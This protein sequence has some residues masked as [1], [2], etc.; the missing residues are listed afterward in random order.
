MKFS[1]G[2]PRIH[3]AFA[4]SQCKHLNHAACRSLR[5]F[6]E[7]PDPVSACRASGLGFVAQP[8]NPDG[9][10]AN[11]RK[12][13]G[14]GAASAPIPLMTWPPRRPGSVSVL[15]LNQQIIV[16]GFV[17]QP[18]N[19]TVFWWTA[20]NPACKFRPHHAKHQARQAFHR[21]HADGL[22]SL[23]LFNDLAATLHRLDLG[24]EAQPRNCTRLRLA[25]L[26]TMRPTLDPVRP[27]GPSSRAYLSLHSSEAP[28]G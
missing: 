18:R 9:F 1:I 10:V 26:A 8:S 21:R 19:P 25:F 7:H 3:R 6:S 23:A 15:W 2:R 14:L 5:S 11:R 27:P 4:S 16:L 20:E 24:F 28:Q 17:E 22:L 12:P 13:R